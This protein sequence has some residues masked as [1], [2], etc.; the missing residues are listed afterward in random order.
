VDA[1]D[2]LLWEWSKG[3][4]TTVAEFGQPAAGDD[5][6]LCVFDVSIPIPGFVLAARAPAGTDWRPGSNGFSYRSRAL[7]PD[8]LRS[9]T[10]KAGTTGTAKA[11]VKGQGDLLPLPGSAAPLPLPMLVQLQGDQGGCWEAHFES[12]TANDGITFKAAGE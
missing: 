5:Y 8:G 9:V 7:T 2:K 10:L 1:K 11:I 4:A 6:A 3:E 12:A